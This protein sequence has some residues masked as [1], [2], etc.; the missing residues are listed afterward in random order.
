MKMLDLCPVDN[1]RPPPTPGHCNVSGQK[2][3]VIISSVQFSRSVM[4]DSLRPHESQHARPP[5]PSPPPGI[6]PDSC[7]SSQCN[8]II[9][10]PF[11]RLTVQSSKDKGE[12]PEGPS[13]AGC[14]KR[15]PVWVSR[16]LGS[17]PMSL[18]ITQAM[19][20]HTKPYFLPLGTCHRISEPLSC[21]VT[22]EVTQSRWEINL[23]S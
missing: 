6:H 3:N 7:P 19:F 1:G 9:N 8:V 18:L 10:G 15:T 13:Q 4:S 5:C 21:Q 16:E 23:L 14:V 17:R 20:S 2:T 12:D 11:H 22:S